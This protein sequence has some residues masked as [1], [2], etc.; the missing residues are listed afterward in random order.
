M[1]KEI[2]KETNNKKRGYVYKTV[3]SSP[4]KYSI[5]YKEIP[6]YSEI[7]YKN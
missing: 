5:G 4:E 1:F 7:Y 2:Q 6:M 3:K